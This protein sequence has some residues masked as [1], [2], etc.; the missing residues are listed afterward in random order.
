MLR[1]GAAPARRMRLPE[2]IGGIPA[3]GQLRR[4]SAV[5]QDQ[6]LIEVFRLRC[7]F[8]VSRSVDGG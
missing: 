5:L 1:C 3:R 2:G 4:V 6:G 8:L 7:C